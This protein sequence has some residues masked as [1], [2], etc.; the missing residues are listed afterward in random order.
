M[1]EAFQ[2]LQIPVGEVLSS[3]TYRALETARLAHFPSPE[4]FE[5]LGDAGKSMSP[6]RGNTRGDWLRSRVARL[7]K[8]GTNTV[9]ITHYPNISEAFHGDAKDLSEGEALVYRPDGEGGATL[10]GRVKI[11]DWSKLG[12]TR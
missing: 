11:E 9:I 2:H 6:A 1:G 4:T 8:A 12:S 10:I 5:E 7:P 3:P